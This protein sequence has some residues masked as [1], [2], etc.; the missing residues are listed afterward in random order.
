MNE[1]EIILLGAGASVEAGIP[2]AYKMTEVIIDYLYD[3]NFTKNRKHAHIALFIVGGL[4]FQKGVIGQNPLRAGINIEDFFNAVN[5]LSERNTLE[6]APFVG[7]WH[8]VIE[9]F[10]RVDQIDQGRNRFIDELINSLTRSRRPSPSD[11]RREFEKA[12]SQTKS[13]PGGGSIFKEL[14]TVMIEILKKITWI[15]SPD[16]IAYLNHIINKAENEKRV[17]IV[18]LNYDNSIEL[19]AENEGIICNLG[20]D[21][22][23]KTGIIDIQKDGLHLLKLHGSIDWYMDPSAEPEYF[24][25]QIRR[26][27]QPPSYSFPPAIIFGQKNK[28]TAEGPFL[29]LLISFREELMK[30]K[31]LIIIGYSFR[32]DHINTYILNWL[33]K[34]NNN[35]MK[36]ID[37]GFNKNDTL[38]AKTIKRHLKSKRLEVID[39]SASEGLIDLQ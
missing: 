16:R 37:P 20:I 22:W 28:L 29:D 23:A 19:L 2:D 36:I 15:E 10:D 25:P 8:S 14:I 5:L 18:T 9:E 24:S 39:K 30:A 31:K 6:I 4:L 38:F 33:N 12:L 17:V 3:Y 34:N 35:Y 1:D 32:D 26:F 13:M 27:K 21:N 11:L 7:S